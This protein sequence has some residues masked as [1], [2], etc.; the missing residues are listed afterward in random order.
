MKTVIVMLALLGVAIP[1]VAQ[2]VTDCTGT[3]DRLYVT[4][5]G[6]LKV[7]LDGTHSGYFALCQVDSTSSGVNKET[8]DVYSRILTAAYLAGK[9]VVLRFVANS[10]DCTP[11]S[12]R[13]SSNNYFISHVKL[14]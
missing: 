11:S 12:E 8:C 14:I 2:A 13:N 3:V 5:A 4:A 10:L 1:R 9:S 6:T 7:R